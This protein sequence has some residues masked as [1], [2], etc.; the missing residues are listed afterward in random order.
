MYTD[1]V[2][3]SIYMTRIEIAVLENKI[4]ESLFKKKRRKKPKNASIVS[5]EP[6]CVYGLNVYVSMKT[7]K[8]CILC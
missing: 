6:E 8:N 3:I 4:L 7:P 2:T 1:K 5:S